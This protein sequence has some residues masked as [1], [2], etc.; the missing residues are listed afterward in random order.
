MADESKSPSMLDL[1]REHAPNDL[2]SEDAKPELLASVEADRDLACDWSR[3]PTEIAD[4][5]RRALKW[6][7]LAAGAERYVANLELD[8]RVL[9]AQLDARTRQ[10]LTAGAV[11]FTEAMILAAIESDPL[12]R[13][14]LQALHSARAKAS[15]C[16]EMPEML[17]VRRDLLLAACARED[18]GPPRERPPSTLGQAARLAGN[19]RVTALP[20]RT[21]I[22]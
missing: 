19:G 21:P 6:A 20:P 10:T 16:G 18:D 4:H 15:L 3:L 14:A 2:L 9:R 17:R 11:K 5:P 1:I 7:L 22:K 12:Y 13:D 8:V